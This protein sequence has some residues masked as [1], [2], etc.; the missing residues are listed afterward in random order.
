MIGSGWRKALP[1]RVAL[2]AAAALIPVLAGCE[3]GSNAPILKIHYPEPASATDVGSLSIRNV[4]VLGAKLGSSLH[5][6]QSAS[7]F[8][9]LL[10]NGASDRLVSISAPGWAAA[11]TI[12]AGGIPV[13]YGHPVFL[14]GPTAQLFLTDLTRPIANGS[15]IKLILTFKKAGPVT[16]VVPVFP[17]ASDYETYSPPPPTAS[18]SGTPTPTT[19]A[20]ARRRHRSHAS[21]TPS[22][23]PGT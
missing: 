21:A 16:L 6:G 8:M 13:V 5:K 12:P 18:P 23:T 11:V 4:F 17:H 7:L 9:A 20:T 22:A 10:T 19:T 3:A 14:S 2:V 15:N 1:R